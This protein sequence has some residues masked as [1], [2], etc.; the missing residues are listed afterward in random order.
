[1]ARADRDEEFCEIREAAQQQGWRVAESQTRWMF[2]PPD[3]NFSPIFYPSTLKDWRAVKNFRA[4]MRQRGFILPERLR[5][6]G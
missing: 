1:M 5:K 3:K 2:V 6:G 4:A